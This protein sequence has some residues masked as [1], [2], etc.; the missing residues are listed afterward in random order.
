MHSFY[1]L[2]A[3]VNLN[4]AWRFFREMYLQEKRELINKYLVAACPNS[5]DLTKHFV[6]F[7][8][9]NVQPSELPKNTT[10]GTDS[11]NRFIDSNCVAYATQWW[12]ELKPCNFDNSDSAIVINAL[13][14]ICKEGG[15]ANH[16]FGASTVK[17]S[18]THTYKSFEEY[19]KAFCASEGK[20]YNATLTFTS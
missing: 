9:P 20:T 14:Q 12:E 1:Q 10:T 16:L 4:I 8:D 15:D 6:H 13:I 19:L 2:N 5:R 3:L 11:L 7:R 18:S 17:P